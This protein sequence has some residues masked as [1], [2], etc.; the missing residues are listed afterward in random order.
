MKILILLLF[1]FSAFAQ[2]PTT[3]SLSIKGTAG[4][5]RSI[6]QQVDGNQTGNKSLTTLSNTAGK[7]PPHGILEFRGY[8]PVVPPDP[9]LVCAASNNHPNGIVFTWTLPE[10][11]AGSE[12]IVITVTS[13]TTTGLTGAI[14]YNPSAG[15]YTIVDGHFIVGQTY[16]FNVQSCNDSDD[17]ATFDDCSA[18]CA[19]GPISYVPS[20]P[21]APTSATASLNADGSANISWAGATGTIT[22]YRIERKTGAGAYTFLANDPASPY[23]DNTLLASGVYTWQ[24]S[25]EN[26]SGGSAFRETNSINTSVPATPI[27]PV[28]SIS[29][30]NIQIAWNNSG[31]GGDA[32]E[33]VIERSSGGGY[34]VL[35][36]I[37]FS[38]FYIDANPVGGFTYTYRIKAKNFWFT[39]NAAT[40][41]SIF[42]D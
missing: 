10:T 7:T 3:G 19:T 21:T 11:G 23:S 27:T 22:N 42:K 32:S 40:S 9:L 13:G 14:F 29:G 15:T 20:V 36:T 39:S 6:S 4:A 25:A 31:G 24:V 37:P 8:P 1:S 30:N 28:A 26:S 35:A 38:N 16:T 33:M 41:N 17:D 2:L 5:G 12:A 18:A 34:S